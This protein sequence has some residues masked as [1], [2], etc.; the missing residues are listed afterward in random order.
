ML[1]PMRHLQREFP[2]YLA[3]HGETLSAADR[4]RYAQQQDL[5]AQ[6]L[7]AYEEEPC[8]TDRVADLM[9]RMQ[10]CGAP[11]AEIAGPVADGVGC[12]IA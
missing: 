6:I 1:E 4:E 2:K 12:S 5:V 8:D 7:R 3:T 10:Q 9:Q 11:P